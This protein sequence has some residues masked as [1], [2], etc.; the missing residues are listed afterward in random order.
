MPTQNTGN[1]G[2]DAPFIDKI[3]LN[4]VHSLILGHKPEIIT[5]EQVAKKLETEKQDISVNGFFDSATPNYHTYYPEVTAEDLKPSPDTFIR[6]TFRALSEVIV[7]KKFNPVDFSK[8]KVL[9]NSMPML[10]NQTV[11]VDHESSIGNAIGSIASVFYQNSYIANGIKIPAGINVELLIDGK[12]HPNIARKI[13]M[14]PPAIHSDSV[15]VMF[16]WEPSH[17]FDN[18]N[19]FINKIGQFGDDGQLIRRIV[20]E[21]KGYSELSLVGHGADPYAQLIKSDGKINNPEYAK[22]IES[23]SAQGLEKPQVY[24]FN[25]KTEVISLSIEDDDTS[26]TNNKP[27][28]TENFTPMKD[29]LLKLANIL[30]LEDIDGLSETE[31]QEKILEASQTA[32]TEIDGIAAKDT[33]IEELEGDL[34]SEKTTHIELKEKTKDLDFEKFGKIDF[35][36]LK[37]T[38]IEE[39]QSNAT[40]GEEAL[41][42]QLKEV[43]R[44]YKLLKGDKADETIVEGFKKADFKM[45]TSYI[46]EYT[47]QLNEKYP[48]K[49]ND[50]QGTNIARNSSVTKEGLA[51]DG[52]NDND[53]EVKSDQDVAG[54][55][56]NNFKGSADHLHGVLEKEKV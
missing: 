10:L 1:V 42:L 11:N 43:Q 48:G 33:T 14:E 4:G 29:Y 53:P 20:I 6:P 24:L 30:K 17:K 55:I 25:Y 2:G 18:I 31:L 21:I 39:L 12:S 44:V 54:E 32:Q 19:E 47:E 35:A 37:D 45:L 46:K 16:A 34:E 36:K 49:C 9:E 22:S 7:H 3:I 40:V 5:L 38:T 56:S 28:P 51:G 26:Q 15:T 13:M 8:N 23:L 41:V 27:T 50:C 52:G